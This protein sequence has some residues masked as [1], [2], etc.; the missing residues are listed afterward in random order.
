M[1]ST[2]FCVFELKWAFFKQILNEHF[3]SL[4]VVSSQ[5]QPLG[6]KTKKWYTSHEIF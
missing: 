6:V 5:R 3:K 4:I 2:A 1:G